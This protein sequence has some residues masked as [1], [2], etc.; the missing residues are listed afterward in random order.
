MKK[1]INV[2]KFKVFFEFL[3]C[4]CFF[5]NYWFLIFKYVINKGDVKNISNFMYYCCISLLLM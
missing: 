2:G 5:V 1:K 4:C 3:E